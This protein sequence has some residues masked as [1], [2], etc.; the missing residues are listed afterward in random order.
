MYVHIT[1]SRLEEAVLK[2]EDTAL[3]FKTDEPSFC[4]YKKFKLINT[5]GATE[6]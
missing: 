4:G 5:Y 6:V 3:L 1:T 2:L